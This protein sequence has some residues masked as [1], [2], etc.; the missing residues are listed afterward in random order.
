M[1]PPS[2]TIDVFPVDREEA[3]ATARALCELLDNQY[4]W[5][6]GITTNY[7]EVHWRVDVSGKGNG[8]DWSWSH[9]FDPV[10]QIPSRVASHCAGALES[11]PPR[12]ERRVS[13]RSPR[14][15]ALAGGVTLTD[16]SA[17]GVRVWVHG[18][19]PAPGTTVTY[20]GEGGSLTGIVK[21]CRPVDG[22][23][24]HVGLELQAPAKLDAAR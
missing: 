8:R 21:W 1:P 20:S 22:D 24:V 11:A 4:S 15:V 9:C 13:P 19:A 7:G 6:I 12:F 10:D 18:E 16:Q 5:T 2:V 23:A 3:R 14:D 17:N